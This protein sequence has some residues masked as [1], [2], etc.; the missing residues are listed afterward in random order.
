[1]FA[2]GSL[3][4]LLSAI[5]LVRCT[6]PNLRCCL[7]SLVVW[8][9]GGVPGSIFKIPFARIWRA[10]AELTSS[11]ASFQFGC[12]ALKSPAMTHLSGYFVINSRPF[13]LRI[14]P[15]LSRSVFGFV[16]V[17]EEDFLRLFSDDPHG[18]DVSVDKL[19]LV[20]QRKAFGEGGHGLGGCFGS[21][22]DWS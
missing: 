22:R 8:V 2:L 17:D 9:S 16:D 12:R 10:S 19:L 15:S 13:P 21:L 4:T 20:A 11:P 18:N 3:R 6:I 5:L 14:G 7:L 1:L